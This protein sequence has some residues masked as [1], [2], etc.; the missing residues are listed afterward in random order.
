MVGA[1]RERGWGDLGGN[2]WIV[3]FREKGWCG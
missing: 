2:F 1:F 3:L